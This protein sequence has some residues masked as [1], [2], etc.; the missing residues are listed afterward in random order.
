M[1]QIIDTLNSSEGFRN[2]LS[3]NKGLAGKEP[4]EELDKIEQPLPLKK[5]TR[6]ILGRAAGWSLV[7][8]LL[9]G[10]GVVAHNIWPKAYATSSFVS[11]SMAESSITKYGTVTVTSKPA[12][13]G[14]LMDGQFVGVTPLKFNWLVGSH[15][16]VLKLNGYHDVVTIV[17]VTE[18]HTQELDLFL[19]PIG[20]EKQIDVAAEPLNKI[21][22]FSKQKKAAANIITKP[23]IKMQETKKAEVN[24]PKM[25]ETKK[26]V[27]AIVK[28]VFVKKEKPEVKKPVVNEPAVKKVEI[29][30]PII[31]KA[32]I[33]KPVIK[34]AETN[35]QLARRGTPPKALSY[36]KGIKESSKSG[37]GATQFKYKYTIQV[38]AF[39]SR[40]SALAYAQSWK[41]KGYDAFILEL[42]GVK[43]PSKLWQSVRIGHFNDIERAVAARKALS[44]WEKVYSYVAL[45]NSFAPPKS[46]EVTKPVAKIEAIKAEVKKVVAKKVMAKKEMAKKVITKKE[47][48]KKII[49]KKVA[50]QP[51]VK[52]AKAIKKIVTKKN[53]MF[54]VDESA[55]YDVVNSPM[56]SQA[57]QE[58]KKIA[59]TIKVKVKPKPPAKLP[60]K[61]KDLEKPPTMVVNYTSGDV[62]GMFSR[63]AKLRDQGKTQEAIE[64]LNNLLSVDPDHGRARRRLARIYV[65]S[66]Q[67]NQALVL[68][69]G[70]VAGRSSLQLSKEEPNLAAFLAALYQRD[71]DHWHAIDLYENLLRRFPGK[72][73]WQMG[74]A[75]SLE[76]V[77][78]PADALKAYKTALNSGELSRKLRAF[79]KKRVQELQ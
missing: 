57:P 12:N 71:E 53:D 56:P 37:D 72:G 7:A 60:V 39:L 9:T 58:I 30:K 76:R 8:L 77:G 79:V 13:V 20:V 48:A 41:N 28:E 38:G 49:A 67:A 24:I 73:V 26:V 50:P 64:L 23:K 22:S 35:R 54:E 46:F 45:W 78:E 31:K 55:A 52:V 15:R 69:Q 75:I 6:S 62:E 59:E 19:F 21:E 5:A 16:L 66:G 17:K 51:Q 4:F 70:G 40:D 42:W 27:P 2:Q 65:E 33:K 1:S 11:E 43:D 14:V 74:L 32:E 34:K 44:E 68:L 25:V 36:I 63:S 61:A 10:A 29:K 18:D 3:S 47:T